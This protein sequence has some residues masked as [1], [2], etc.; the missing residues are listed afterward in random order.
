MKQIKNIEKIQSIYENW[1]PSDL[2]F[3]KELHWS[4][5][6]LVIS[7]LSQSKHLSTK[8]PD[9]SRGFC[10][11]SIRFNYVVDLR[12]SFDGDKRQQILGLSITNLSKDGLEEN[13]SFLIEDYEEGTVHFNC[14]EISIISVSEHTIIDPFTS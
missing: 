9:T 3:I 13:S 11:V 4:N 10:E 14:A 1:H 6:E 5:G 2:A 7:F 8:W 12:F